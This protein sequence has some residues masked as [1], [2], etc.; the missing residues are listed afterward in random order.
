MRHLLV[1]ISAKSAF[2]FCEKILPS[3]YQCSDI[4]H[5]YSG[6]A[7]KMAEKIKLMLCSIITLFILLLYFGANLIV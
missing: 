5:V 6:T 2:K 3:A 1:N 4:Y 7:V